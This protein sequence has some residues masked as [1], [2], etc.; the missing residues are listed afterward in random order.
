MKD[1]VNALVVDDPVGEVGVLGDRLASVGFAVS[2][3]RDGEEALEAFFRAPPDV[4]VT[5][6]QVSRSGGLGL[7]R[8]IRAVSTVPV[9]MVTSFGSIPD[10]EEA[11]RAGVDR[12]L[13]LEGEGRHVGEAV[14]ELVRESAD[15]MSW[16]SRRRSEAG[17]TAAR[18]RALAREALREELGRLLI[19]CRGNVAEMA[20]RMGRDRSTVRYHL[21][22]FGMLDGTG[23]ESARV[24]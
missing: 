23:D 15:P 13:L 20:R 6:R 8:Q 21:R 19:L 16:P 3:A 12:Y 2:F 1:V 9:V 22:R 7:V 24:R 4:V 17:M 5:G 11:F 18:M 14:R 10:C